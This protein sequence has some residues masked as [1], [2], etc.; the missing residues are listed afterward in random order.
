MDLNL[1][2]LIDKTYAGF[3][4]MNIGIRLGAPVEPTV[5]TSERIERAYGN[6]T[7]Y[8]KDFKNFAADDDVNGPVYFLRALDDG[9]YK[10]KLEPNDVAQAWLN[11][12]RE[13]IGMFWW[14]GYGVSTEHTAYLN[15]KNGIDAPLSGSIEVNG[16]TRA[17]QIGGQIF[18]DTWGFVWPGNP[19]KASEYAT[20][21]AS[22]SHDGE[23]LFGASFIAACIA[24]AYVCSDI[25][26]IIQTGLSLIPKSSIYA[27]IVNAVID[28]HKNNSENWR[29]CLKYLQE[30]WGYDKYK[31]VCHIIPNAGVCIMSLLYGKDINEAVEIATM[32]GWDTDCNAG[33]VGSIMGVKDGLASIKECYRKP[34]NDFIVLSGI[35]GYLNTLDVPTYVKDLVSWAYKLNGEE[36]PQLVQNKKG[37]LHFDFELPGSTHGFRVSNTNQTKI[38]HSSEYAKS[39]NGSLRIVYDRMKRGETSRIYYKPFYRRDDFDDERYSPSFSPTAYSNQKVSMHIMSDK[40]SGASDFIITPYVRNSFT[41]EL[42]YLKGFTLNEKTW[43]KVEFIIPDLDGAVCD[44][45]GISLESNS[46][47]RAYDYGFLYLDDFKITGKAK[48]TIKMNK[49]KPEFRTI[50]PFSINHGAWNIEE[51]KLSVMCLEHGEA[52]TGNYYSKNVEVETDITI[53]SKANGLIA[54][55]VQGA[56]RG[57]YAG[58]YNSNLVIGKTV[59]GKF[60]VIKEK[61][62]DI[63]KNREYKVKFKCE[64]SLFSLNIDNELELTCLDNSYKYGMVGL[65]MQDGGRTSFG[66]LIV[67]EL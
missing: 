46:R 44:E 29:A 59:N 9:N 61:V 30:N 45:I 42:V 6:I 35:S 53:E 66:T 2:T 25:K 22:V 47:I 52:V 60:E 14:G 23:G 1:D 37:E 28:F 63:V 36:V 5:W 51:D 11:Y 16:K 26:E 7:N 21:A 12:A 32:A 54:L 20:T 43:T 24:K 38:S 62:F 58:F 67:K 10:E 27:N 55:R 18:I 48:Y 40:F 49:Q 39:G 34:I 56:Q 33:N 8:V 31:G 13:E 17:E 50:T 65:S 4:A 15:L 64:D 41:K 3:L 57:Y 19:K